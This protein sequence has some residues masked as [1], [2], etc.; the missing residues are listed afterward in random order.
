MRTNPCKSSRSI[1]IVILALTSVSWGCAT[2]S[3]S[4]PS[5]DTG[6]LLVAPTDSGPTPPD[7]TGEGFPTF[8]ADSPDFGPGDDTS[9]FDAGPAAAPVQLSLGH[10]HS[11][12]RLIDGTVRCWGSNAAGELG[13]G[14]QISRP[15]AEPVVGLTGVAEVSTPTGDRRT[16]A[17]SVDGQVTCW[18]ALA[19]LD[20]PE[21]CRFGDPADWSPCTTS[22]MPFDAP[23]GVVQLAQGLG[24]CARL[25]DGTVFCFTGKRPGTS[26]D[27]Y[28]DVA[29]IEL[30]DHHGCLRFD[31]GTLGCW[32]DD[33]FGQLGF[34]A[35]DSCTTVL[36]TNPCST[37]PRPIPLLDQVAD[38]ALGDSHTCALLT[39][40]TVRCWG[41]NFAGQLGYGAV[42]DCTSYE[43]PC[44]KK[45]GTV[46]AL[47][48]ATQIAVGGYHACALLADRTVKCWGDNTDGEL[49]FVTTEKCGGSEAFPCSITPKTVPGLGD[50]VQLAAGRRHTCAILGD[51]RVKCWGWNGFGQLGDGTTETRITPVRVLL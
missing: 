17:R 15:Y 6:T 41:A 10:A 46:T 3:A 40:G 12:V 43:Y 26:L 47:G 44:G 14:T 11:C 9:W 31:D 51:G 38:I 35:P 36:G 19:D 39:D 7:D 13:D 33:A 32:G 1:A 25:A 30:G 20:L 2:G 16:C 50:V 28:T 23:P 34:A 24:T 5:N 18:G 45:P 21:R 37:V 29:E 49:G 27:A 8:D 22:P 48:G 4:A 42:D